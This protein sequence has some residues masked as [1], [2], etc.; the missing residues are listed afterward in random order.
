MASAGLAGV[1]QI[2]MAKIIIGNI[3]SASKK[4]AWRNDRRPAY[5]SKLEI[6]S[7]NLAWWLISQRRM[8]GNCYRKRGG[9]C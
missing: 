7:E 1:N 3:N 4:A 8:A 2:N 5:K 6:E 9:W